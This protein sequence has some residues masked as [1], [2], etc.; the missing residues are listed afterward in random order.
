MTDAEKEEYLK[1]VKDRS[2]FDNLQLV[3][4]IF[5]NSFYG[6]LSATKGAMFPWK[7]QPCGERVTCTGRQILRLLISHFTRIGYK[8]IV[9]DSVTGDTPLFIRYKDTGLIN[10]VPIS[11]IMNET[12]IEKDALGREYDCSAK[13]YQV[14]CRSGWHDIE[15]IY[16][17]DT[18]KSIFR[19]EQDNTFVDV[20]QDHSLFDT[21]QKPIKQLDIKPTTQLETYK[22][23]MNGTVIPQLT[24]KEISDSANAIINGKIDAV[25]MSILNTNQQKQHLFVNILK[26]GGFVPSYE[27]HS[28]TL[29]AGLKY[30]RF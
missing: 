9:G 18:D 28:K 17:H 19:V 26:S 16:R 14:L 12:L 2:T 8:P 7:S 15:Y 20:T 24:F 23:S 1:A 29:L 25:P 13:P 4:K 6:S 30:I 21:E 27:K 3:R 5:C 11:S 22:G 10:I